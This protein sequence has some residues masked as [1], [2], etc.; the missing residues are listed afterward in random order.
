MIS[1]ADKNVGKVPA[2][3]V[4]QLQQHQALAAL[5]KSFKALSRSSYNLA[6]RKS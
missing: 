4:V 2:V 5:Q 6:R 1:D 3:E